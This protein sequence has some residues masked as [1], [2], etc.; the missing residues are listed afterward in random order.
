MLEDAVFV[1]NDSKLMFGLVIF[2]TVWLKYYWHK[3]K[4]LAGFSTVKTALSLSAIFFLLKRGNC[5]HQT[6]FSWSETPRQD[7]DQYEILQP[8]SGVFGEKPLIVSDIFVLIF[9]MFDSL[10]SFM[11]KNFKYP[12]FDPAVN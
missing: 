3:A 11:W 4:G 8:D 7:F 9:N 5:D 1:W 10:A 12:V 2:Q 6:S